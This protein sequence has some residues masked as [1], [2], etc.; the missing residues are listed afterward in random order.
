M[1]DL[2]Y[3]PISK[4]WQ[5][6]FESQL[7]QAAL[8]SKEDSEKAG[9]ETLL[10]ACVTCHSSILKEK[11]KQNKDKTHNKYKS[12]FDHDDAQLYFANSFKY[13]FSSRKN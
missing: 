13:A 11:Y 3:L 2:D 1:N 9:V 12:I 5:V 4:I 10:R 7:V 8:D 6:K